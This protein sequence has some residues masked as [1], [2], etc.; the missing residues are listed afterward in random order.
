MN[1]LAHVTK[2]L[3]AVDM[4]LDMADPYICLPTASSSISLLLLV[5]VLLSSP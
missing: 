3:Q 4:T 5:S 1:L 2:N